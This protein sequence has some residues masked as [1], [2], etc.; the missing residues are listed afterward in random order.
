MRRDVSF[1]G[2]LDLECATLFDLTGPGAYIEFD[3]TNT[4]SLYIKL[5]NVHKV[6]SSPDEPTKVDARPLFVQPARDITPPSGPVSLLVQID[7]DQTLYFNQTGHDVL[8]VSSTLKV[9]SSHNI[10]VMYLSAAEAASVLEFEGIWLDRGGHCTRSHTHATNDHMGSQW[11]AHAPATA[12]SKHFEVVTAL[13]YEN[14]STAI[15]AWLQSLAS[16]FNASYAV[17]PASSYCLT[18]TC[19]L[20]KILLSDLYFRSGHPMTSHFQL[21]YRFGYPHPAAL[22]SDVGLL[23]HRTFLSGKP[24]SHAI[25]HFTTTF[26]QQYT[27]FISTIRSTA[28]RYHSP[29]IT[30]QH[31]TLAVDASFT[32][33]SAP[34][35]LPIFLL[36]PFTPSKRLHRLLSH[37][38]SEAVNA[39]QAQGDK[40]TFWID[41]SGWLTK[42]DF[43]VPDDSPQPDQRSLHERQSE[44]NSP[45]P[46]LTPQ[47]HQ[48]I[49]TYLSHHLCP[50]LSPA[51]AASPRREADNTTTPLSSLPDQT[52]SNRCSFNGYDNY[53]GHLYVPIEAD[54]SKMLEERKIE[55]VKKF[56][57]ME[58]DLQ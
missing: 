52:A 36:T 25:S 45:L 37:A 15:N 32:Y 34:S 12:S 28:Y 49:A 18:S 11:E 41:T 50:Y 46:M 9:A 16:H 29:Y 54:M 2:T 53:L 55:L 40:S 5:R 21:P 19:P 27:T 47:A 7:Q 24:S 8:L 58:T 43:N 10:K 42:K 48:R 33:N 17:F 6:L 31:G 39:L 51:H 35:T 38:V 56:L 4:S 3:I 44:S 13:A 14:P 20:S 22:I 57:A 30:R 23:D 26:V 1:P